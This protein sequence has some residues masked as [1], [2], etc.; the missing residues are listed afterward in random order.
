LLA[1][2][3]GFGTVTV[4][5]V[6][7]TGAYGAGLAGYLLA[8]GQAVVEI[9]RPD[10]KARRAAGKSDPLDAE[11]AARAALGRVRTGQPKRHDG[12][13]EALRTCGSPAAAP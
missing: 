11:S 6:E 10:L 5:G 8:M 13:G 12:Q 9:D 7:G 2:L 1:W 4:V 3:R